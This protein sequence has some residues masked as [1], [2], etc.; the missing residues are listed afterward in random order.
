MNAVDLEPL[1]AASGP[2]T[3]AVEQTSLYKHV[4]DFKRIHLSTEEICVVWHVEAG[5]P[6]NLMASS[7]IPVPRK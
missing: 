3:T 5:H 2:Q 4:S 6:I 7:T 1:L